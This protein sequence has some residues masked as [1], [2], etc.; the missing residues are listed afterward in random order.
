MDTRFRFKPLP[1]IVFDF[2][3]TIADTLDAIVAIANRLAP[4]Y[5]FSPVTAAEVEEYRNLNARQ[6]IRRSQVPFVK[7]PFLIRRVQ[8]ELNRE[9]QHLNPISGIPEALTTLWRRGH[10]LGIVTSN[11]AANVNAFLAKQQLSDLFDFVHSGATL[12]GKSR[13]IEQLLKQEHLYPHRVIYVGDETRDIDA[14][15]KIQIKVISVAWGF[16]AESVLAQ[17][18]PDFLIHHPSELVTV[19]E[20]LCRH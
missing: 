5:G 8:A 20:Q 10:R 19:L 15:Q 17:H 16:N 12:F 3:G 13:V 11:S 14:A 9:I 18:R 6:A 2:D 7:I 4:D 1:V